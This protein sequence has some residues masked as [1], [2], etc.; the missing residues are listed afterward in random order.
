LDKK[1]SSIQDIDDG[2]T[3][4]VA[5]E[6]VYLNRKQEHSELKDE[7]FVNVSNKKARN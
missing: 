5:P 1:A 4:T 6:V 2:D 7:G 3:V